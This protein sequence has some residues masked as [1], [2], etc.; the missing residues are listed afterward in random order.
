MVLS[1]DRALIATIAAM[2]PEQLLASNAAPLLRLIAHKPV[3][4]LDLVGEDGDLVAALRE[5]SVVSHERR[6][7]FFL[8]CD[9]MAQDFPMCQTR[10]GPPEAHCQSMRLDAPFVA[11]CDALSGP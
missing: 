8:V 6:A 5:L 7:V 10:Q 11:R 1:E 9:G 4:Q 3:R 2:P